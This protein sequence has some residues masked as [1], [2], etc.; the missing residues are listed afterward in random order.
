MYEDHDPWPFKCP[1]CGEEFTEQIGRLKTQGF[2]KCPGFSTPGPIPC[3]MTINVRA[4]EFGLALTEAKAGR[5][6]PF[7]HTW[8]R[9]QRP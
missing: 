3:P 5:Y 2:A 6:D 7:R 1:E 4:E 8:V 9:K